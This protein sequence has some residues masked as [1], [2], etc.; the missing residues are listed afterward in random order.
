MKNEGSGLTPENF[1][2]CFLKEFLELSW[3]YFVF[4]KFG[5]AMPIGGFA[6]LPQ[7]VNTA[8]CL[9]IAYKYS[10]YTTHLGNQTNV[11]YLKLTK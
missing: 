8:L 10:V 7:L 1:S 5:G 6:P 11:N 3:K 9:A 4:Q 2:K